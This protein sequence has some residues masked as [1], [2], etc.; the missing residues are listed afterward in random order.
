MINIYKSKIMEKYLENNEH[1]P[2]FKYH[3][4]SI[5][6]HFLLAGGTGTGKTNAIVSLLNQYYDT[7]QHIYIFTKQ[8]D[9]PIYQMLS[10]ELKGNITL[11]PIDKMIK[12]D[13]IPSVGQKMVIFDDF[14]TE[15]KA[16]LS[17]IT[18]YSIMARK[19]SCTCFYLVQSFFACPITIRKNIAYI[20]LLK[21]TDKKNLSMITSVLPISI[22]INTVK[23]IIQNAT[24]FKMNICIIDLK[25]S[26]ETEVFRRNITDYYNPDNLI[27]YQYDGLE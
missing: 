12:Y 8:P 20:I 23:T 11:L 9:E 19:K 13:D 5:N 15:N 24:K 6:C 27:L 3:N 21:M 16:I 26:D 4:L 7:F 10:N 18:Q 14:I 25:T 2:R 17:N 22:S 1:N